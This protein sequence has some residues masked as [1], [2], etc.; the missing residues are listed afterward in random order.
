MGLEEKVRHERGEMQFTKLTNSCY[1]L[2]YMAVII[3]CIVKLV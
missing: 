1:N 2:A 3:I